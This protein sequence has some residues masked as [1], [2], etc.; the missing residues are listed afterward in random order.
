[1]SREL[2]SLPFNQLVIAF[3]TQFDLAVLYGPKQINFRHRV[4][5]LNILIITGTQQGNL[6]LHRTQL[7]VSYQRTLLRES[8]PTVE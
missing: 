6:R 2:I 8:T 7:L 4:I 5:L 3:F 1:M